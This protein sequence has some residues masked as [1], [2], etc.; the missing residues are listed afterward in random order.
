MSN[1]SKKHRPKGK[2]Y[3]SG[4]MDLKRGIWHAEIRAQ[5]EWERRAR[6]E[7]RG[8]DASNAGQGGAP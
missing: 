5:Q 1:Y 4:F 7:C 6:R 8:P 2:G 3:K